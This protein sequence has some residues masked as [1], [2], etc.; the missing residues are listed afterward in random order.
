MSERR[1]L[2]IFWVILILAA[3]LRVTQLDVRPFH[4]DEGV[5]NH[6]IN[7]LFDRGYYPYSH[8]N[9]HGPLYFY[10]LGASVTFFG[11]SEAAF[12]LTSVVTGLVL[13]AIPFFYRRRLGE[14]VAL[15]SSLFLALSTSMIFYSR[16][17]IHEIPFVAAELW[18]GLELLGWLEDRSPR[19]WMKLALA[20]AWHGNQA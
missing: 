9:Y 12:R 14:R 13:V 8:E 17:A 11:D 10:L 1:S 6:F 16:Y 19:H 7:E 4:H 15:L 20:P 3:L 2:R 18:F 5:N